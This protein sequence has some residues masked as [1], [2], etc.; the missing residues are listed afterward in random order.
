MP[1]LSYA[2]LTPAS[3]ALGLLCS[4]CLYWII[5]T[6][7]S[8]FLHP[9]SAY[10]GPKLW[11]LTR[12]PWIWTSLR[13]DIAWTIRDFHEQYGPVI[14]IAP[15]ELSYTTSTAGKKIYGQR[16]PEFVKSLD[17]RGIVPPSRMGV[18][19]IVT[20]HQEKH[21]QLRRAILPAFS[22]RALREQESFFQLYAGKLTA[23]L[24][25]VCKSGPQD[26]VRWY[27][28]T[29]F[30]IVSDLAFGEAA[31]CLDNADSPWLAVLGLRAKSLVWLQFTVYYGLYHWIAWITPKYMLQAR[32]KHI[33][34]CGEKIRRR[35]QLKED[36]KD[37]MS[38]ILDNKSEKLS[39][40]ELV[41]MAS[42]F[43]VAGSRTSAAA[44]SGMTF[45]LLRNPPVYRRLVDEIRSAFQKE[46]DITMVATGQL[47][48][49]GAVIEEGLRLYP[50]SPSSLPR[51]VPGKGEEIDGKWVPGGIAVG[52][53]QLSAGSM[54]WNFHQAK[55]FIPGRWLDVSAD[56]P[57]ANDISTSV[58]PFSYGPRNCIGKSM[59]YAE[60]R[61]ILAHILWKFDLEL[62]DKSDTWFTTQ[63]TYL[64]WD[65]PPLMINIRERE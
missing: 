13:G 17:G 14:R 53:H 26:M 63:K 4:V 25:R 3:I 23:Q 1:L 61:L 8:L 27:S 65:K 6:L 46:E 38:Y 30:D 57:F 55:S 16:S 64:V 36:R 11:A 22:E 48:Y 21:A 10:P 37:F 43:I 50:P 40:L 56:S 42:A 12:L 31:G 58:Q 9:L 5:W 18:R 54:E 28:F 45:F 59:A 24:S 7:Y 62:V 19:G 44:L 60:M 34:L 47:R 33:E 15:D 35:L 39:N 52:V 51:F 20:A 2:V 29:T 32:Q 41:I 49:L